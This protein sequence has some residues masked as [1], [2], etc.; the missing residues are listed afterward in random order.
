[1]EELIQALKDAK[2]EMFNEMVEGN[3][4]RPD[5]VVDH[6][7]YILADHLPGLESELRDVVAFYPDYTG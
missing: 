1:M 2:Q 5:E 4:R 6:I 7:L 3:G